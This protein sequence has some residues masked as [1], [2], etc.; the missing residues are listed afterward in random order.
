MNDNDEDEVQIKKVNPND[1]YESLKDSKFRQ[2]KLPAWRPYPT[3]LSTTII[4]VSFGLVSLALGIVLLIYAN[5]IIEIKK[6]YDNECSPEKTD[7]TIEIEI[8]EKM[9]K[10]VI[11]YYEF[12]N[13]F[14][15][16]R[17]YMKSK[18]NDQLQGKPF[19]LEEMEDSGD[20]KPA[21]TNKQM[22]KTHSVTK[23]EL[24]PEHLAI[25][26]GLMAKAYPEERF[27]L[28]A[29]NDE[30][31]PINDANISWRADREEL[32]KNLQTSS[33]T[34]DREW[35]SKQWIDMTDE[36]FIVWMRPSNLPDFRKLYGRIE[37]D[38]EKG[39]YKLT[40]KNL[41]NTT[42]YKGEKYFI[43]TT[44]NAFGGKNYFL[45]ISYI[46]FGGLCLLLAVV[47]VIVYSCKSSPFSKVT[48]KE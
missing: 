18:S 22:G 21:T 9:E 3:I 46:V 34:P 38:L 24:N 5:D 40:I 16:H 25:P 13:F 12:T 41:Y 43:L 20:C 48:K 4:F 17:R 27:Y 6:R 23:S 42:Q 19:T 14:Q 28:K 26:C 33:D 32:F 31:I 30:A 44:V 11:V 35:E 45:A 29:P 10:K 7:C 47:F 36:H 39:N 37:K 2:Q 1:V 15:N 8:K